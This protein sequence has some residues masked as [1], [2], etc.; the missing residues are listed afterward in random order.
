MPYEEW[1]EH[2]FSSVCVG[3]FF[4]D[5]KRNNEYIVEEIA[6]EVVCVCV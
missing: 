5:I 3:F 1:D 2:F 4:I 6:D